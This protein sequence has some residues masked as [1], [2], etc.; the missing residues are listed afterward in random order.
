[1]SIEGPN[2]RASRGIT[3]G[4]AQTVANQAWSS[5]MPGED[6]LAAEAISND[7]PGKRT[8]G[9][10]GG[11][12]SAVHGKDVRDLGLD[13]VLLAEALVDVLVA[14]DVIVMAADNVLDLT[15][16]G[17][18]PQP[19]GGRPEQDNGAEDA[20]DDVRVVDLGNVDGVGGADEGVG[21]A[22]AGAG[23]AWAAI[24]GDEGRRFGGLL[25]YGVPRRRGG[26]VVP[27]EVVGLL[28]AATHLGCGVTVPWAWLWRSDALSRMECSTENRCESVP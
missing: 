26:F 27:I 25:V 12:E 22:T 24:G 20:D 21:A 19:A 28:G 16:G 8:D 23:T 2:Q 18:S 10:D 5:A 4:N 13:G 1:M 3:R 14:Q 15:G 7:T 17:D 11:L 9:A 6:H